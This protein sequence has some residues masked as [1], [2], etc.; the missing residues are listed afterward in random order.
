MNVRNAGK[1]FGFLVILKSTREFNIK[2]K[3]YVWK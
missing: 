3:L 2:Q 1:V